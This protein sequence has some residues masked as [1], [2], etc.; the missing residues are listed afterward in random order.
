MRRISIKRNSEVITTDTDIL[1]FNLCCV[2]CPQ[3]IKLADWLLVK[4][5]EYKYSP[6]QCFHCLKF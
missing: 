6:Q 5:D 2:S 1:T 3:T 4:V